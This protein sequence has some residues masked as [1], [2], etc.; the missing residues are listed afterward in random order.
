MHTVL[1]SV[2]VTVDVVIPVSI[3]VDPPVVWV[4]V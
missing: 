4:E 3:D 1:V 2:E